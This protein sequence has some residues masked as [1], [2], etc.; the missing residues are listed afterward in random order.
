MLQTWYRGICVPRWCWFRSSRFSTD[1]WKA[2]CTSC[3]GLWSARVEPMQF[4]Q[5]NCRYS[6]FV[7]DRHLIWIDHFGSDFDMNHRL[8]RE[9]NLKRKQIHRGNSFHM[10]FRFMSHIVFD[11]FFFVIF[12]GAISEVVPTRI[13][14]LQTW[15]HCLRCISSK[16]FVR[17]LS[18]ELIFIKSMQNAELSDIS[19]LSTLLVA[20]NYTIYFP[21]Q[22]VTEFP[23]FSKTI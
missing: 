4:V 3:G 13:H 21:F 15:H 14:F 1:S 22:Q 23:F 18:Y 16:Y 2:E 11:S 8:F 19:N 12:P 5:F 10:R 9:N 17:N 7:H 20:F 6:W